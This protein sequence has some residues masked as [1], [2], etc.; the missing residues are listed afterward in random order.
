M[1]RN[2]LGVC[3]KYIRRKIYLLLY[4]LGIYYSIFTSTI[5]SI[6]ILEKLYLENAQLVNSYF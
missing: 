4:Y 1:A 2:T 6:I 5:S 3:W